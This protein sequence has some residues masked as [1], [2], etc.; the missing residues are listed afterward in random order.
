M[1]KAIRWLSVFLSLFL[2]EG[3]ISQQLR[4]GDNPYA[5]EKS[6]VLDLVSTN[7]GLLLPRIADTSLINSL[8]PPD[9]MLIYYTTG[10]RL[11][12]RRFGYWNE[13]SSAQDL[14]M[15]WSVNGNANGGTKRIGNTDNF[16]LSFITN[17]LERLR[18]DNTGRVGIG[19]TSPSEVLDVAGNIKW[20][21]A[22]MPG[23]DAGTNG[24]VLRSNGIGVAPSWASLAMAGMADVSLNAPSNGQLLKY[25]GTSWVN[26]TPAYL[27]SVDTSDIASFYLKTRSL[28]SAGT[29]LTYNNA[30]GI[31]SNTGV[32]SVN[33][34]TGAI[35]LDTGLI[36]NFSQKVRSLFTPIAP[37][38]FNNNGDIGITQAGAISNGY[39]SSADWAKFNNKQTAGNYITNLTG[40]VTASGPGSTVATISNNAVSYAKIQKTTTSDVVLGRVSGGGG[41]VEEIPTTG[42]GNVVRSIAPAL[43]NPTGIVKG[44]VGLGNVDNTSDLSK[45]LSIATQTA[46][47]NKINITE[48]ASVN[49]VATLD[50]VGK[51][52]SSQLPVGPQVYLGTWNPVTNTPFLSDATG[53][54]GD[55][56]RVVDDGTINLGSGNITFSSGDD[57]IHNGTI[58]Q[59][60]PATSDVT[61]VNGQAGTVVLNS[62]NITEGATNKYYTDTRANLKINITEKAANN[63]VATLDA[64]GKVPVSQLPF[65]GMIYKGTWDASTNTPLLADGSGTSGETYN[66]VTA[67]TINLGSGPISFVVGDKVI[68]NG[69]VWQK[70]PSTASVTSVNSQMG[71]V[72]LTTDNI[73]E[74]A[75]NKYYTDAR[76]RAAMSASGPL[77]F[78]TSTGNISMPQASSSTSG[79]LSSLDWTSFNQKQPAGNYITGL[80]GDIIASGPGNASATIATNS[81][82]YGKLQAMTPNK[83]LGSGLSGNAV[84]EITLGTGLSFTG[85][86]LNAATTGGTVTSFSAGNLSPLFTTLVSNAS[87]TPALSFAFTSQSPNLIFASP[88][89]S[90]GSPLFRALAKTD[91]PA[92][93]VF[94]NQSNIYT[95]G[96][97]QVF[98]A[99]AANADIQ[100][101]GFN[102]DPTGLNNGD[103][104]FNTSLNN[105]RYRA[106]GISRTIANID[107]SQ[108]LT[109]KTISGLNNTITNISNAALANSTIGLT[110]GTSGSD[111]NVGASP[112]SLGGSLTLNLP[113]ASAVSR[114]LLTQADWISFNNKENV[115]SF[116]TG[117][118]RVANTV[119]SNLSTGVAGGQSVVGGKN[120]SDNLVLSSTSNATKGNIVLGNS[121]YNEATNRLG[122]GTNAP[123]NAVHINSANPLRLEGLQS[124]NSN[125]LLV[126]DANG[127]VGKSPAVSMTSLI[128]SSYNIDLPSLGNNQNISINVAVA[129][130]KVGD[131]VVVT[132][133]GELT[134]PNGS[135]LVFIGYSYVSVDGQVTIRFI[136]STNISTDVPNTVFYITVIR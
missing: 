54:R 37:I 43:V 31:I 50:A 27:S 110:L 109:N 59:R 39:L 108:V 38:T 26:F 73:A 118:T 58:W 105:L 94:N 45:P 88:S 49:G 132:P 77:V 68:Y 56:Y 95:S 83:L 61:S 81:V 103:L 33:G 13:L 122:V 107:E 1:M 22:L 64:G 75:I 11:L 19:T 10:S 74:G 67:G 116:S 100:L 85:N 115:L 36:S 98:A 24:Y 42:S 120:A 91:L 126:V 133:A 65:S 63:G 20:S 135:G 114:G 62:D 87:S 79:Y 90:A 12:I 119:T 41:N 18:I 52:P 96:S 136:N 124:S 127:V 117:L 89:G 69:T 99:S 84:S 71:T 16:H 29:G 44:D 130:A 78:N 76:S 8:N 7:Q 129:G 131:N 125:T 3:A 66:V 2:Y 82:T 97:K 47:N 55:T 5:I 46:L 17:N 128:K 28:F 25:N 123:T 6:A 23:N 113:S 104:W 35:T 32:T 86:T 134:N 106:N 30:T 51:I 14:N 101:S 121:V 9:G 102:A 60:N 111:A 4:L 92:N 53:K 48:K 80:S 72:V 15:Y 21:G 70:N 34:N 112:A 93:I 40:D 57:V